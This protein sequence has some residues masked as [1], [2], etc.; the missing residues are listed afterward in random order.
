MTLEE[1]QAEVAEK[2]TERVRRLPLSYQQAFD[3][4]FRDIERDLDRAEVT[5]EQWEQEERR[6]AQAGR[7]AEAAI[8]RSY[9]R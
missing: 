3:V 1:A 2:L 9:G 7:E 8:S 4:N 6:K 5:I